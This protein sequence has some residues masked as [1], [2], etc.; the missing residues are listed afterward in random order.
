MGGDKKSCVPILSRSSRMQRKQDVWLKFMLPSLDRFSMTSCPFEG[1]TRPPCRNL[2]RQR[3]IFRNLANTQT[4]FHLPHETWERKLKRVSNI[5][6]P[7]SSDNLMRQIHISCRETLSVDPKKVIPPELD[8][9]ISHDE[10]NLLCMAYRNFPM[11]N[12]ILRL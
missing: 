4:K 3:R 12:T 1:D 8:A 6:A 5:R 10:L 11:S 2:A 9:F 7:H